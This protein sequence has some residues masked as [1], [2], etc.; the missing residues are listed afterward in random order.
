MKF[1]NLSLHQLSSRCNRLLSFQDITCYWSRSVSF[2]SW[3]FPLQI[4]FLM[5]TR[6]NL[7]SLAGG[8]FPASSWKFV[9]NQTRGWDQVILGQRGATNTS[10]TDADHTARNCNCVNSESCSIL[11]IPQSESEPELNR[12]EKISIWAVCSDL[13]WG[14]NRNNTS[15][16]L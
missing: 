12:V 9:L 8:D 3:E 16:S 11:K 5:T 15:A 4:V 7:P 13:L 6:G 2:G 14:K 10:L 1:E